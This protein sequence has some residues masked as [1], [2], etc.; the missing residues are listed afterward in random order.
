MKISPKYFTFCKL[1]PILFILF[2]L[3][4]VLYA[5]A[6]PAVQAVKTSTAP[7]IDGQLEDVWK[8]A[9][10]ITELYQREPNNGE[11]ITQPTEVY[12]LYDAEFL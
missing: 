10:P 1:K 3:A 9:S 8:Q 11:L 12:V 4:S 2:V 5:F 7:V 6:Q